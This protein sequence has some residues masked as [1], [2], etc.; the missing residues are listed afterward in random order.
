MENR[1]IKVGMLGLGTVGTGVYK[2]LKSQ[3]SEMEAKLGAKVELKKIL[4]RNLEKASQKVEDPSILTNHAGEIL[5][6]PEIEIVIEVMGG[7]Q[8]ALTYM[9]AALNAGKSV[10]TANKDVVASEGKKLLDTAKANGR[11]FLYE[12]SV[13][14][15]IPI[16]RPLKQCLAGNHITEVIGIFNGTTNFILTK[17]SKEGMEFDEALQLAQ[18]LGYAEADP[19]SD[20]EGLDAGR[21]VAILASA[22]FNSRV[23]FENVYTEGIARITARD[24]LYA[25]EMG[26]EIKLL[27]VARLTPEGIEARV[28]PM[29][30]DSDHPLASVQDSYNAVFVRGD[31]VQDTMFYGR[32]AGEMPTASA[33]VGDVFD[34]VRNIL[35][36]CCGRIGCTCY[37]DLPV[38]KIS[39]I[40]SKYFVRMEVEDRSG[41][42]ASVA[43][44]FGNNDVSIAQVMQKRKRSE[45]AEIVVITETVQERHFMDAIRILEGMSLIR[46]ISSLIRVYD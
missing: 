37:K 19:T 5:E 1:V 6:D 36:D 24:I 32:G 20:I 39:D 13:A 28:H 45:L 11:D 10:V 23:V 44:V 15:G 31:A 41:V 30:I 9:L 25:K 34:C 27:G 12:A 22:A 16:I 42:L 38:R 35:A 17:M 14:G 33:V 21:K 18:D 26:C 40:R 3:E 2:V 29:L 8:P 4:V 46:N 7:M 43:A